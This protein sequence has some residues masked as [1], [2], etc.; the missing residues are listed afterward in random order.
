MSV[1]IPSTH[2]YTS[3]DKIRA[4]LG[5]TEREVSDSQITGMDMEFRLLSH[6]EPWLPDH[7]SLYTSGPPGADVLVLEQVQRGIVLYATAFCA[8][9]VAKRLALLA[10]QRISDGKS[11]VERQAVDY[12]ALIS[13]LRADMATAKAF[14]EA[15]IGAVTQR[16]VLNP[17]GGV[18]PSYNPVTN[19]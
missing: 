12:N 13:V 14:L 10:A 19:T 18:T 9:E 8:M 1:N 5:V 15:K 3:T 6:L 11:E 17:F 4:S 7:Y 16:T 2:A